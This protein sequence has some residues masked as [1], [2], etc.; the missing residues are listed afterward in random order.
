MG[1]SFQIC[2]MWSV[3]SLTGSFWHISTWPRSGTGCSS[4]LL[5]G[6]SFSAF[7]L[8]AGAARI[9]I[10]S[11][12]SILV[13]GFAM[14]V[15]VQAGLGESAGSFFN[16]W[17][18]GGHRWDYVKIHAL[19]KYASKTDFMCPSAYLILLLGSANIFSQ[20]YKT[21]PRTYLFFFDVRCLS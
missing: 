15:Y 16:P 21:R 18:S 3:P 20:K 1:L 10:L 5:L 6:P 14:S 11:V 2:K 12:R 19:I 8:W 17:S 9:S 4:H 7:R 13:D